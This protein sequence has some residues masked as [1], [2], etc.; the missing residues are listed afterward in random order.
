MSCFSGDALAG[1]VAV[2]TGAGGGLGATIM[3]QLGA[4]GA[5]IVALDLHEIAIDLPGEHLSLACDITRGDA[6]AAAAATVRQRFGLCDVLVNNAAMLPRPVPIEDTSE[7][8]WNRVLDV[9]LTGAFLC[10]RSFGA[11]MLEAGRGSVVNVASIAASA[12]NAVGAY[13]VSKAALL[14]LTRQLAV[15][16]GGRRACARM[17]SARA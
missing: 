14:A 15:A 17:P 3:V 1:R 13:G 8:L 11:Q 5:H 12:P 9:N 7:E 2:V 6:V 10:S 16:S 4:M